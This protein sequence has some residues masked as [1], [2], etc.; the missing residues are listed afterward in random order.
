MT[1]FVL[2]LTG[3]RDSFSKLEY[4]RGQEAYRDGRHSAA[5]GF[6]QK[7]VQRD[8]QSPFALSAAI[9]GSRIARFE[10]KEFSKA[11]QF[12]EFITM[13]SNSEQERRQSQ[14]AIADIYLENLL[15]PQRAI[16]EY[17]KLTVLKTSTEELAVIKHSLAKAYFALNRFSDAKAEVE[18]AIKLTTNVTETY[19]LQ[20]FLGSIQFNTK[21]LEGALKTYQRVI[22]M[23]PERSKSENIGLNVAVCYEEMNEFDSAI[24]QL[25]NLKTTYKDVDFLNLKI[26]R[27]LVRKSNLPGS[28]GWRK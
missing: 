19:D 10:T 27:L 8:P 15:Q 2:S 28:K 3:C 20:L 21:D 11:I 13:H 17:N 23:F 25:E 24:A 9:D 4:R 5:I 14:K 12:Y 1:L 22:E 6:Y 26:K 16:D 7:V 18:G